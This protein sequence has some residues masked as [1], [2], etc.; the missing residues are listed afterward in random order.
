MS[1]LGHGR[2]LNRLVLTHDWLVPR[3]WGCN[4][5]CLALYGVSRRYVCIRR[6]YYVAFCVLNSTDKYKYVHILYLW[7]IPTSFPI[8]C[9]CIL[10]TSILYLA[11]H[12]V[13]LGS[14][15]WPHHTTNKRCRHHTTK[16]C[17][18]GSHITA[19]SSSFI[20]PRA[21]VLVR[22][23]FAAVLLFALSHTTSPR[24]EP[25]PGPF[26][27]CAFLTFFHFPAA[28]IVI[29]VLALGFA[30]HV[31]TSCLDF[32]RVFLESFGRPVV[33][34]QAFIESLAPPRRCRC[35]QQPHLDYYCFFP[36]P[37]F[38]N[39]NLYCC[40]LR[41]H[42]RGFSSQFLVRLSLCLRLRFFGSF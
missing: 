9:T 7:L 36:I 28:A 2:F 18:P 35:F 37:F 31:S 15:Q 26:L 39:F 21:S 11:R 25:H 42:T 10:I 33:F 14:H 17:W 12:S 41:A 3:R 34:S 32:G 30:S 6:L 5:F 23:D 27:C 13:R 8:F 40:C 1:R 38:L 24:Q 20:F 19:I 4:D 22:V 29:P 16:P